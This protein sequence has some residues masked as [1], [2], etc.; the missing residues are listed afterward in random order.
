MTTEAEIDPPTGLPKLSIELLPDPEED[1]RPWSKYSRHDHFDRLPVHPESMAA[2]LPRHKSSNS[3]A[4]EPEPPPAQMDLRHSSSSPECRQRSYSGTGPSS[5]FNR[6]AKQ[7][8]SLFI[9]LHRTPTAPH[10]LSILTENNTAGS[11]CDTGIHTAPAVAAEAASRF[12]FTDGQQ[13]SGAGS[14]GPKQSS[15]TP[16]LLAKTGPEDSTPPVPSPSGTC[17]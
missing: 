17:K 12:S 6:H 9:R 14:P 13:L 7:R 8:S 15:S 16:D 3:Q 10:R 5:G 11:T 2:K 4:R 1:G